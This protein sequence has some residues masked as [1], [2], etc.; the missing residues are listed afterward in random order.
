MMPRDWV[1]DY[2]YSLAGIT[3]GAGGALSVEARAIGRANVHDIA[4][5]RILSVPSHWCIHTIL[6]NA[7]NNGKNS[8]LRADQSELGN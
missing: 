3:S 7:G 1:G 2:K 6:I 5:K 4:N 8:A